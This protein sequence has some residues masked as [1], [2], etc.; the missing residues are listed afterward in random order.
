MRF[1]FLTHILL[2]AF[3]WWLILYVY[4]VNR[5]AIAV[6]SIVALTAHCR[7]NKDIYVVIDE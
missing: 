3:S 4:Q 1:G 2:A 6:K 7:E 5:I